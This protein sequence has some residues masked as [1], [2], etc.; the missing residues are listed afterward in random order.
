MCFHKELFAALRWSSCLLCRAFC[1]SVIFSDFNSCTSCKFSDATRL[2]SPPTIIKRLR[3][4]QLHQSFFPVVYA[5]MSS[6]FRQT[7]RSSFLMWWLALPRFFRL[8]GGRWM[9]LVVETNFK[10]VTSWRDNCDTQSPR[11][12]WR[13]IV[14]MIASHRPENAASSLSI[15]ES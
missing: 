4:L 1:S 3:I 11:G 15:E 9:L 8:I 12:A 13:H 6:F 10:F 7:A 5:L 14:T 2:A